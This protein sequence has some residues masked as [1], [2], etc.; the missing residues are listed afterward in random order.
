MAIN[1]TDFKTRYPEFTT[2][3][4]ARVQVHLDDALL[5]VGEAAWGD[6]YERGV[7]LLAAHTLMLD[8]TVIDDIADDADW[9]ESRVTSRKVGDVSVTLARASS[10][11]SEEDW[12]NQTGYGANYLRLKKRFG[13]GIAA[14]GGW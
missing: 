13:M 11:N 5:E 3:A 8:P 14:V 4:D 9:G 6:S 12:Y 2:V 7:F 10:A 1:P